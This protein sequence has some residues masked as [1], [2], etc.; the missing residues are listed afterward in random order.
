MSR[1]FKLLICSLNWTL[2]DTIGHNTRFVTGLSPVGDS[3]DFFILPQLFFLMAWLT[4]SKVEEIMI[5]VVVDILFN[6]LPIVCGNS[7]FDFVLLCITLCPSSF[8]IILKKKRKLVALLLLSYR[9]ID[10]VNPL[11][12]FLVALH[13]VFV[14]FPD[15]TRLLF[16]VVI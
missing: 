8:A 12:L 7:V 10:T 11:W 9:C 1:E 15:R 5:F 2:S 3:G 16:C 13:C 4:L 14:V 6:V